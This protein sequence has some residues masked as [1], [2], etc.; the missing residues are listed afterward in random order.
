MIK[1]S[2]KILVVVAVIVFVGVLV[3][4][5][6]AARPVNNYPVSTPEPTAEVFFQDENFSKYFSNFFLGRTA[7]GASIRSNTPLVRASK[8]YVKERVGLRVETISGQNNSFSIQLRFLRQDNGE[9]TPLLAKYRQNFTIKPGLKSYCCVAIPS[10]TGTY[11]I[12]ILKNNVLIGSVGGIVV[13]P[14]RD[15]QS[16]S[17]VG[18]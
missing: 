16:G 17:M 3:G 1:I 5:F 4:A 6:L 9:E 11:K 12:V 14:A 15:N 18:I 8:F 2:K 7:D 13:V 10:E